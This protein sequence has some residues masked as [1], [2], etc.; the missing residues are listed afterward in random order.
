MWFV[1]KEGCGGIKEAPCPFFRISILSQTLNLKRRFEFCVQVS[2]TN[3]QAPTSLCP[4]HHKGFS[5]DSRILHLIKDL[6]K[7]VHFFIEVLQ[8]T[9]HCTMSIIAVRSFRWK[10]NDIDL[11]K[12]GLITMGNAQLVS[13]YSGCAEIE[14][15]YLHNQLKPA[16]IQLTKP[17]WIDNNVMGHQT[18]RVADTRGKLF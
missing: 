2:R 18:F 8:N 14:W 3:L 17:P 15:R 1:G 7:Y 6:E 5:E 10:S 9:T 13:T 12:R 11:K 16:F 4:P